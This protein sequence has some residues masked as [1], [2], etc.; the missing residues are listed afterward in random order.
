MVNEACTGVVCKLWERWNLALG[1]SSRERLRETEKERE[2]N[3]G[4]EEP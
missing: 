2:K 1:K 4:E 3:A